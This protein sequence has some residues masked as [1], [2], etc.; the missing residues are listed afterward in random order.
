MSTKGTYVFV[1]CAADAEVDCGE[2]QLALDHIQL[3][4]MQA[5]LLTVQ[6]Q[7]QSQP[8]KPLPH[9]PPPPHAPTP[10]LAATLDR[11]AARGGVKVSMGRAAGGETG[12]QQL[13]AQTEV[14]WWAAGPAG[15][16]DRTCEK[17]MMFHS[18]RN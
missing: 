2:A 12:W 14:R 6:S 9:P 5:M 10:A 15:G 18:G 3:G 11:H 16:C 1:V 7:Q 4:Q 13:G 8:K 17:T